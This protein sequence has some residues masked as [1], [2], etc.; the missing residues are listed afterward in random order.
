MS[1]IQKA[2]GYAGVAKQTAKGSPAAAASFLFGLSGGPIAAVEIAQSED[3][4]TSAS[5]TLDGAYREKVDVAVEIASRVYTGSAGLWLL[6]ALGTV[7]TTGAGD[8]YSHAFS[9]A[10]ALPYLTVF[11]S[12]GA[13]DA[14]KTLVQDVKV[15]ELELKWEGSAPV[16]LT[17]AGI[18]TTID[19]T[20]AAFTSGATD[21]RAGANYFV[22]VGGTFTYDAVGSTN[23]AAVVT[24]GSIKISNACE[25][26][27]ASGSIVAS[28][29]FEGRQ[30]VE[31]ELTVIPDNVNDWIELMSGSTTGSAPTGDVQYGSFN[32]AFTEHGSGTHTLTITSSKIAWLA[33]LP[34]LD[35]AGGPA[36]MKLVG[37]CYYNTTN[38]DV[39]DVT[40]TSATASY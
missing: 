12:M 34:E 29:V 3:E 17:A 13:S 36:E 19:P 9:T 10:A 7:N 2:I 4:L 11:G 1:P 28:D 5:R 27:H 21:E 8:P 18:G 6:G 32:I 26:I 35:P 40:L 20:G 39:F 15:D 37:T 16:E 24:D 38:S 31:V 33:E 30:K 14:A 22:P 23:A 25:A